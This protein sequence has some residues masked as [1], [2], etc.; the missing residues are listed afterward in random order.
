MAINIKMG[1]AP[2]VG[3]SISSLNVQ[4][5]LGGVTGLSSYRVKDIILDNTHARFDEFGGWN[6]IGTIFIIPVE[7]DVNVDKNL[8]LDPVD[9]SPAYPLFPNIKQY[10]LL[11]EIVPV[12]QLVDASFETGSINTTNYYL[13][14]INLWNSQTHNALPSPNQVMTELS[15]EA[16]SQ[17]YVAAE[18]GSLRRITDSDT[19]IM[20]GKTFNEP[21]V[22][23]NQPLLPLF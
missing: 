8:I 17:D 9:Y 13:P 21:N 5:P 14:P 7:T 11:E 3:N 20:L 16:Q 15:K 1:F 19:D 22:I 12:L 10:P 2:T 6:G 23:N 4:S 18:S